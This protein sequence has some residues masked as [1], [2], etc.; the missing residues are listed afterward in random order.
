MV[1]Y[2]LSKYTTNLTALVC[3]SVRLS[4]RLSVCLFILIPAWLFHWTTSVCPS[5]NINSHVASPAEISWRNNILTKLARLTPQTNTTDYL[6]IDFF[7][8][9][10]GI[11]NLKGRKSLPDGCKTFFGCRN[12][13]IVLSTC[14]N[15]FISWENCRQLWFPPYISLVLLVM[16]YGMVQA[17]VGQ[18]LL[19]SIKIKSLKSFPD[20]RLQVLNPTIEEI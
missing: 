16:P 11:S 13:E 3:L 18:K 5:V 4:V 7:W 1:V 9:Q 20:V 2:I 6:T 8:P 12:C 19:K 14:L 17:W 10:E 15:L